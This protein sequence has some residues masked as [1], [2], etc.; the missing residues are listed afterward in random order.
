M[1]V[2]KKPLDAAVSDAHTRVHAHTP[3][4]TKVPVNLLWKIFSFLQKH[5]LYLAEAKVKIDYGSM[6][7]AQCEYVLVAEGDRGNRYFLF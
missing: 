1:Q 5:C 6:A 7:I 2:K 3:A 4:C